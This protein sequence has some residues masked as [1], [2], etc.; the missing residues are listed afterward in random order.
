MGQSEQLW[1]HNIILL[2]FHIHQC[3][4]VVAK[5]AGMEIPGLILFLLFTIYS[6]PIFHLKILIILK[7]NILTFRLMLGL[8]L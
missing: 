8:A 6:P 5:I 1:V 2:L 4:H 3:F 7:F